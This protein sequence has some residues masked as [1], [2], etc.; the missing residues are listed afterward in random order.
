MYQFMSLALQNYI[1]KNL[2]GALHW[3]TLKQAQLYE[4][5]RLFIIKWSM[6]PLAK[7]TI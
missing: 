6:L 1:Y 5:Q 4:P 3:A 2:K 7:W